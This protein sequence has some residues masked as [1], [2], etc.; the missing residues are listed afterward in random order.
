MLY[1]RAD[2]NDT[3]VTDHIMCYLDIA[4]KAVVLATSG[5]EKRFLH[6]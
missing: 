2:M 3:I 4:V 5:V 6:G 1:I